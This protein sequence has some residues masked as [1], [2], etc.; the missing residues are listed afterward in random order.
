MKNQLTQAANSAIAPG[1]DALP[2]MVV[3]CHLRWDFVYQRPQHL[4]SRLAQFYRIL[5]IEEPIMHEGESFLKTYDPC[6]NLTVIQAHTPVHAPGFHDDQIAVLAPLLV[7]LLPVNAKPVVWF[8]TPMALP[9]LQL[10]Q[11]SL[12]VYDCMDELSAFKNA[13]KQLLQ[14]ESA[15]LNMADIVFTGGPSLYQAKRARN[16]NVHCFP[17]SVDV[18]HFSQALDRAHA[19]PSQHALPQPRL[20]YYG[21]IDERFDTELLGKIADA[22]PEWQLVMVGPVV[23]IDP[24]SLPKQP[25][26][27]YMG[28]AKYEELPAYLAAWQVCL[29]PFALNESTKFISPTKVL[30]Y[31]AAELPIVSTDI[32]D[33]TKPY[34]HIVSI[35][36][37]PEEFVKACEEAL[38]LTPER[39]AKVIDQM[40]VVV[41]A[42]SWQS[43]AE[44]MFELMQQGQAANAKAR[45]A[46][47]AATQVIPAVAASG[48]AGYAPTM[49]MDKIMAKRTDAATLSM[50]G[51]K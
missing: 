20:G 21:V 36:H 1:N 12:V 44:H 30:E 24:A 4:L 35:A 5:V 51:D 47:A 33:V 29:M 9:L 23:K 32:T 14:R 45:V 34:G 11:P 15:L 39:Q 26:I 40:R 37:T 43:T 8:Y 42:T 10:F 28:Q 2:I 7:N 49:A 13:P 18:A 31:M 17:S 3:F 22:H 50:I 16:A 19:H 48:G 41:K 6:P 46:T 25:N 27:H 38:A